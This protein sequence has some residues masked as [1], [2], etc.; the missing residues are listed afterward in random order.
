MVH[1]IEEKAV[2]P[3]WSCSISRSPGVIKV[4]GRRGD[5]IGNRV[6]DHSM[7]IACSP[8]SLLLSGYAILQHPLSS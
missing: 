5:G 3:G 1:P 6:F 8:G 2:Q 4:A 7:P